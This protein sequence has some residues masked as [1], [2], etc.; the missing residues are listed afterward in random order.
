M[1]TGFAGSEGKVE[2]TN[3]G[4]VMFVPAATPIDPATMGTLCRDTQPQIEPKPPVTP[5]AAFCDAGPQ[6]MLTPG[7]IAVS[8]DEGA[9]WQFVM[10]MGMT[11]VNDDNDAFVDRATGRFFASYISADPAGQ[12]PTDQGKPVPTALT[13]NNPGLANLVTS[14]DDGA[15]WQYGQACCEIS[16]E[17]GFTAG[18]VPTGDTD[19]VDQLSTDYPHVT[20]YCWQASQD[21]PPQPPARFCSKSRDAGTTWEPVAFAGR[22][23]VPVHTDVCATPGSIPPSTAFSGGTQPTDE[24]AGMPQ[25]D[26]T[27]G[28]LY[29]VVACAPDRASPVKYYIAVSTDEAR[30]WPIANEIDHPGELRIDSAGNVYL[31]RSPGSDTPVC[32]SS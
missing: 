19:A 16:D 28:W 14:G 29:M 12:T 30:T 5:P 10:P 3:T 4:A 22:G 1:F 26:P 11:W 27:T 21:V 17:G 9:S 18:P 8:K 23:V 20:Y 15:S 2:V 7:G 32:G 13:A 31:L 25:V 24:A 6:A